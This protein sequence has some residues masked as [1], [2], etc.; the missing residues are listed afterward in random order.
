LKL[1]DAITKY[2]SLVAGWQQLEIK[3]VGHKD[4]QTHIETI[5]RESQ[6]RL[7]KLVEDYMFG[8]Q[9]VTKKEMERASEIPV[10]SLMQESYATII[11]IIE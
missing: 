8:N 6:C 1:R 3:F 2:N 10:K 9:L 5:G 4:A 7:P 11:E